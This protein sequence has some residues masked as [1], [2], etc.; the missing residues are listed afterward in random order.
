M[1]LR[2]AQSQATETGDRAGKQNTAIKACHFNSCS[3]F[4]KHAIMTQSCHINQSCVSLAANRSDA[5]FIL[6][7]V[8]QVQPF[9]LADNIVRICEST[10]RNC[11]ANTINRLSIISEW[12]TIT[13]QAVRCSFRNLAYQSTVSN[14]CHFDTLFVARPTLA[15]K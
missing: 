10:S 11:K 1:S 12:P 7:T 8:C 6:Q 2:T 5:I 15:L 9:G 3:L 14:N 13:N 4:K